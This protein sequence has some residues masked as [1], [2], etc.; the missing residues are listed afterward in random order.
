LAGGANGLQGNRHVKAKDQ[1]PLGNALIGL[2][3][4]AGVQVDRIGLSN[5]HFEI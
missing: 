5:G 2:A 1:T 3:A 4:R